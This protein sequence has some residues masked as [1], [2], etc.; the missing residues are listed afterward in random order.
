MPRCI[1]E[2]ASLSIYT[3]FHAV[4]N[5]PTASTSDPTGRKL[6]GATMCLKVSFLFVHTLYTVSI[7]GMLPT[8][9]H[10][11]YMRP[12]HASVWLNIV[13]EVHGP[14]APSRCLHSRWRIISYAL[15]H[16]VEGHFTKNDQSLKCVEYYVFGITAT[17][18]LKYLMNELD[19]FSVDF[20]FVSK[21][22]IYNAWPHYNIIY[23][24]F[25]SQIG[26]YFYIVF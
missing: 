4:A 16:L 17:S 9:K 13:I 5:Y 15:W 2:N 1:Y 3:Y 18:P 26:L 24:I 14:A 20:S 10:D 19:L 21:F 23:L 11:N 6:T 8:R 25:T 22:Y 12:A 7:C